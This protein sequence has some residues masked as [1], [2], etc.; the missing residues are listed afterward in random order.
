MSLSVQNIVDAVS[1]D[2]RQQ[3]S[4]SGSDATLMIGWVDR[5]HKDCLH[6]SLY[7]HLN[8]AFT[9]QVLTA[10][11]SSYGLSVSPTIRRITMVYDRTFQRMLLPIESATAPYPTSTSVAPPGALPPEQA[12]KFLTSA[13]TMGPWPEYYTMT[14]TSN[15]IIFPAPSTATWA[16]TLE[17]H[18]EQQVADLAN[19]SDALTIPNDGK[20]IVVAGVNSLALFYLQKPEEAMVWQQSYE[21]MKRGE[22]IV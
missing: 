16:G 6:S 22:M 10:G 8:Q 17:I 9:T 21:R 20:D 19:L 3:L 4:N 11:V 12:P 15:L 18:Y 7:N 5:I 14:N 2:V 13:K 1:T